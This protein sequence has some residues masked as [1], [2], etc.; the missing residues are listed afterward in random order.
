MKLNIPRA[1]PFLALLPFLVAL[2]CAAGTPQPGGIS[3][4]PER[5]PLAFHQYA[6]NMREV[7]PRP[8]I[9]A[10]FDFTN[11]GD[12][13]VHITELDASCGCLAPRLHDDQDTYLPGERGRFYVSIQTANESPGPHVYTVNVKYED[14]SP[15]EE[16]VVFRLTLPEKKLSVEPAE[17][18]FYPAPGVSESKTTY[19]TDFRGGEIEVTGAVCQLDF[20]KLEVLPTETDERGHH[21][22]P[23]RVTVPADFPPGRHTGI[24]SLHTADAEFERLY[25]AVLVHGQSPIQPVGAFEESA[26]D[27]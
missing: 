12:E 20:V 19:V 15:H 11:R 14:S 3:E 8:V 23:V 18:I 7:P 27:E 22:V 10:H 26:T 4:L 5:P 9:Q 6:V 24:I 2:V 16:L 21:R 13:P 17:L 1:L 25:A